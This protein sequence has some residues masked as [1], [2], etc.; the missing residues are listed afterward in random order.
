MRPLA[1]DL[2]HFARRHGFRRGVESAAVLKA[3]QAAVNK[4]V[5]ASLADYVSPRSYR[6]GTLVLAAPSGASLAVLNAHCGAILDEL[7]A[8]LGQSIVTR[9]VVRAELADDQARDA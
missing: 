8:K 1:D 2:D 6:E 9:V 7:T 4:L 5:P 3:A